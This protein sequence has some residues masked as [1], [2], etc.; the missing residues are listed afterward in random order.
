MNTYDK[1]GGNEM[2]MHMLK[3]DVTEQEHQID[4]RSNRQQSLQRHRHS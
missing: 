4:I 2:T 1:G 3:G